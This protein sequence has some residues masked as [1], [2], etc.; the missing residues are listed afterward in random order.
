MSKGV[1][2]LRLSVDAAAFA[3][4]LHPELKRKVKAALQVILDTPETGKALKNELS[5]L[6]S[7]RV[8]RFRIIY[9]K[10]GGSIIDIVAI[11]PRITIYE[12]TMRFV[13]AKR[14]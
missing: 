9:K 7:F 10:A 11:G 1:R 3:R 8:G 13:H 4:S 2:R 14:K 6:N 5:G 12:E